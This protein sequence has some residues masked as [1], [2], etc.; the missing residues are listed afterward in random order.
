MIEFE[1]LIKLAKGISDSHGIKLEFELR[2]N[3]SWKENCSF[4]EC[5]CSMIPSFPNEK[6]GLDF[7]R[8]SNRAQEFA[9]LAVSQNG[10]AAHKGWRRIVVN[11]R[12]LSFLSSKL[13]MPSADYIEGQNYK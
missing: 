12:D 11:F 7:L 2:L 8:T 6:E 4:S 10:R 9:V 13:R 5:W 3:P 1:P